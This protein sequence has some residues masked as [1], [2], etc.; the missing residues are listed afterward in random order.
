V[1]GTNENTTCIHSSNLQGQYFN[2]RGVEKAD[3]ATA[4]NYANQAIQ[5]DKN[6]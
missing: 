6:S 1:K 2:G 3:L 5:L 4:L